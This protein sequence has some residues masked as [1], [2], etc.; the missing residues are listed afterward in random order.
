MSDI[1]YFCMIHEGRCGSTVLGSLI[2]QHPTLAHFNE[3]LTPGSWIS[4]EFVGT[5]LEAER[6]SLKIDKGHLNDFIRH[7]ATTERALKKPELSH[8]GFEIK[9]NQLGEKHLNC[10]VEHLV[11]EIIGLGNVKFMFLTRRNIIKRHVSTLRCLYK[12]V[13]HAKDLEKVNYDKVRLDRETLRDWS[14]DYTRRFS[15]LSEFL[16]S[17]N[18]NR[19]AVREFAQRTGS[20]YM[21]Y[22][23]FEKAPLEGATRILD[24]LG[25]P[26]IQVDS[27]FVKTGN[28]PLSELIDNY[29]DVVSE[30]SGTE[31]RKMLD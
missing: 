25:L 5:A 10:T 31:W 24:F 15:S 6:D 8:I 28:L 1:N 29:G 16:E 22:E 12:E 18:A 9:L 3:I 30:L 19:L 27:P 26:L 23:D 4:R 20:L 2:G 21:E 11:E 13:S 17:S 14:Y 7:L